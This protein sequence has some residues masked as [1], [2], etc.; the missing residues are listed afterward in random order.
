MCVC[1]CCGDDDEWVVVV[2]GCVVVEMFMG[3]LVFKWLCGFD[4]FCGRG[5]MVILVFRVYWIVIVVFFVSVIVL[6][7]Y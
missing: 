2:V 4:F 6:V 3:I 7:G 5:I 1:V